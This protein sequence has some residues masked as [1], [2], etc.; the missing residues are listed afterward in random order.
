MH[1]L[2]LI[3]KEKIG[4][5]ITV[6]MVFPYVVIFEHIHMNNGCIDYACTYIHAVKPRVTLNVSSPVAK[7]GSSVNV[8]CMAESYPLANSVD[9]FQM[10]H[11]L[12]T[13]IN[14]TFLPM[15]GVVHIIAAASKERDAGIYECAVSVTLEEYTTPLQSDNVRANLLIYGESCLL[16]RLSVL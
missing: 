15:H 7:T 12:N 8:T 13:L 9:N 6:S 1:F 14:R 5:Y 16:E 10:K 4:M 2:E 11:P 3:K